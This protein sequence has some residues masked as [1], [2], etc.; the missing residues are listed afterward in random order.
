MTDIKPLLQAR[1][2][3]RLSAMVRAAAVEQP[4]TDL[5]GRIL[6]GLGVG[7]AVTAT[8]AAASG[9]VIA[10]T[11]AG[12]GVAASSSSALGALAIKWLAIG[13]V[14]GVAA[15]AGLD[16]AFSNRDVA[17]DDP[18]AL[19]V[20]SPAPAAAVVHEGIAVAPSS[21]PRPASDLPA[22]E[23]A[24]VEKTPSAPP[25]SLAASGHAGLREEL[26][27]I[28]SARAALAAGKHDQALRQ[29]AAYGSVSTTG[30]LDREARVLRIE[31]LVKS[32]K[33][34]QAR[35]LADAYLAAHPNDLHAR[36]L[37]ELSS[38]G[39]GGSIG[40]PADMSATED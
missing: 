16:A 13:T 27:L 24:P 19:T 15:A 35:L 29:L 37:R 5:S 25:P 23:G 20:Q 7:A 39:T 26:R 10:S 34:Q 36:R 33:L 38:A 14:G 11:L 40:H 17:T 32:G 21:E 30:I 9:S 2:G 22:T 1:P 8:T 31:A 12:K 3:S 4:S 6:A 18:V 28:D